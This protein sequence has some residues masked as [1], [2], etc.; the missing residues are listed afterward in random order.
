LNFLNPLFWAR[1]RVHAKVAK[2]K[3]A[4]AAEEYFVTQDVRKQ[5]REYR[6]EKKE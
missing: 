3:N 6:E 2:E 1:K 5:T 4:K